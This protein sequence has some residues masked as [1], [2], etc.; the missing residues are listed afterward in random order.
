MIFLEV[1]KDS[2]KNINNINSVVFL[3]RKK[4]KD[5]WK[6]ILSSESYWVKPT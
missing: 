1:M 2:V 3:N 4:S 6:F 5:H